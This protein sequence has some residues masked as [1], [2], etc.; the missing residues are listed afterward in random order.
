MGGFC[1]I[2]YIMM[3]KH[4]A[5][6]FCMHIYRMIYGQRLMFKRTIINLSSTTLVR[7]CRVLVIIKVS[8]LAVLY[9]SSYDSDTMFIDNNKSPSVALVQTHRL[10]VKE[11]FMPIE[12]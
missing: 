1:R 10:N 11:D 4:T 6:D 7:L 2:I 12:N 8:Q 9:D 5:Y 3:T